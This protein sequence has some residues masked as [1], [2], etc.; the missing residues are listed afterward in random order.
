M[1][2][3]GSQPAVVCVD[4]PQSWTGTGMLAFAA[5]PGQNL[6][7][8]PRQ[9]PR[10]RRAHRTRIAAPPSG[11]CGVLSQRGRAVCV[12]SCGEVPWRWPP[13]GRAE[14]MGGR[15]TR[16]RE[17]CRRHRAGPSITVTTTVA[18][19][20]RCA[21][22]TPTNLLLRCPTAPTGRKAAVR[23]GDRAGGGQVR[24][25]DRVGTWCCWSDSNTRPTDYESVALPAE[26]QQRSATGQAMSP[27]GGKHE[28]IAIRGGRGQPRTVGHARL[29]VSPG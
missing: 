18:A 14:S 1:A 11:D 8:P 19:R 22:A 28:S 13:G 25:P 10:R 15:P 4:L 17:R 16:M 24:T 2:V 26:L 20:R 23:G 27:P 9:S 21:R 6:D 7:K 3:W 12:R 29:A 5:W